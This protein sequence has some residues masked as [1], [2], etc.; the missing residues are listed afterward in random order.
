MSTESSIDT[1]LVVI[2]NMYQLRIV[3]QFVCILFDRVDLHL[4]FIE[5]AYIR[6]H[7]SIELI[8][9]NNSYLFSSP[10]NKHFLQ[11]T[12]VFSTIFV[13][14]DIIVIHEVIIILSQQ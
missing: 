14:G 5:Q 10:F 2:G 6:L 12:T 7:L 1:K 13:Q 9:V 3:K 4:Y 11:F 8:S